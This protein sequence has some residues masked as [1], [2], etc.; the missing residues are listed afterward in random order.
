M[1]ANQFTA[2]NRQTN[3]IAQNEMAKNNRL[4]M[5]SELGDENLDSYDENYNSSFEGEPSDIINIINNNKGE[6]LKTASE[7]T[8]N[9]NIWDAYLNMLCLPVGSTLVTPKPMHDPSLLL[10]AAD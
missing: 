2:L 8:T 7:V 10:E 5:L 3:M 6:N 4:G 9:A 1:F